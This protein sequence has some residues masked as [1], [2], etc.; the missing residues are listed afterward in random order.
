MLSVDTSGLAVAAS[1]AHP[2]YTAFDTMWN[3]GQRAGL[4][5]GG[6]SCLGNNM[7]DVRLA[8]HRDGAPAGLAPCVRPHNLDEKLGVARADRV[9]L[10]DAAGTRVSVKDLLANAPQYAA[11]R[12]LA[13]VDA[14]IAADERVVLRFQEAYVPLP[15][16]ATAA[17]VVPVHFSYQTQRADDPRNLMFCGSAQGIF[18]H[19]DAP[20]ANSLYAHTTVGDVTTEH[21]FTA[22]ETAHEVGATHHDDAQERGRE[23][24]AATKGAVEMGIDGAG[25]Q[26]NCFVVVSLPNKQAPPLPRRGG[27]S[28]WA[29]AAEDDDDDPPMPV[30]RSLAAG[31][32]GVARSARLTVDAA[33]RGTARRHEG[34]AIERAGRA[35]G[36]EPIVVTVLHYNTIRALGARDAAVRV[37]PEDA[38][39]AVAHMEKLYGLCDA[40][41]KLSELPAMLHRLTEADKARIRATVAA[42]G[43]AFAAATRDA[44]ERN[45]DDRFTPR[46]GAAAAAAAAKAAA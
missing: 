9:F 40:T 12:G 17:Q 42:H 43:D 25:P 41:C 1:A 35:D 30:Y 24:A 26:G 13:K 16:G 7:T 38:A 21:L 19:P 2:D 28:S 31:G 18:C 34:L 27:L 37:G 23:G 15:E 3:D 6:V 46:P 14:K 32:T 11:Y 44:R 22:T 20:G 10:V 39:R 29:D 36:P 5:G 4:V 33:S 8:V 45:C